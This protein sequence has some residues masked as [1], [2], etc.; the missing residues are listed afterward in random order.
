LILFGGYSDGTIDF[1]APGDER[2]VYL[3]SLFG[4]CHNAEIIVTGDGSSK[5]A[6]AN[7]ILGPLVLGVTDIS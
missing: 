7:W 6:N 1:L 3:G 5:K 2:T 4:I